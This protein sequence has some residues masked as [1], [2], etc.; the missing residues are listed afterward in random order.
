MRL[1]S[2]RAGKILREKIIPTPADNFSQAVREFSR[3]AEKVA[4]GKRIVAAAGGVASPI[5]RRRGT[6]L[7]SPNLPGWRGKQVQR[8]FSRALHG[9]PVLLENDAA[10]A[11]LGEAVYGAGK[12][13]KIVAYFTVSTGIGGARV[14]EKAIDAN[15][16]GFEPGHQYIPVSPALRSLLGNGKCSHCGAEYC[17]EAY[18]S[19]AALA[20]AFAIPPS[21]IRDRRVWDAAAEV[22]AYGIH[23]AILHWSPEVVVMGGAM[24]RKRPGISLRKV[25]KKLRELLHIFP[26]PPIVSAALGDAAGLYGALALLSRGHS[27]QGKSVLE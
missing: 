12:R 7:A 26:P 15:A 8:A 14:V 9:V 22:L 19:G 20:K 1:A 11:A 16:A 24:I 18:V 3:L 10:V 4:E 25:Q 13:K 17:L 5:S 27:P 21:R 6:L 2:A 23:N